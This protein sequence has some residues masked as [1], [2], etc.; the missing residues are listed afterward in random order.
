MT[1]AATYT[2]LCRNAKTSGR[3]NS[4]NFMMYMTTEGFNSS[5][6]GTQCNFAN[7]ITSNYPI[8]PVGIASITTATTRGRHGTINDFWGGSTG[9]SAGSTYPSGGAQFAQFGHFVTPWNGS[10]PLLS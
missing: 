1:E 6:A 2:N 5:E 4:T 3:H 8:F 7:D 9:V 10:T